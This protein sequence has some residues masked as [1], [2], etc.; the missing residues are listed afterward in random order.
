MGEKPQAPENLSQ[1]GNEFID[2]CLQHDPK[3]RLSAIELLE[4]NFCKVNASDSEDDYEYEYVYLYI[5]LTVHSLRT[6]SPAATRSTTASSCRP[7][8]V[9]RF[10]AMWCRAND[11]LS[12]LL[13][14]MHTNTHT[15]T[16]TRTRC[17]FVCIYVYCL[18]C[19]L[20]VFNLCERD[21]R[22]RCAR[23]A[24]AA[25]SLMLD[26]KIPYEIDQT[27]SRVD[28]EGK[29]LEWAHLYA[30]QTA[31]EMHVYW[32]FIVNIAHSGFCLSSVVGILRVHGWR[33]HS[34]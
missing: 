34:A 18:L 3:Q 11:A 24:M 6:C 14:S 1:E 27:S 20:Y 19:L 33:L 12:I 4:L 28:D 7:R 9:A 29:Q 22:S 5:W 32:V 10:A 25:P 21:Q 2:F 16:R 26:N 15:R 31:M 30:W 23:C 8:C 17:V 13:Y